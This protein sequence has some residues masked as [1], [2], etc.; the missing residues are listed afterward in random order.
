MPTKITRREFV[1][2]TVA[3]A[4]IAAG[5]K[6]SGVQTRRPNILFIL[7]DDLGYGDLSCYGRPDYQTSNLDRLA[8]EGVRF[9]NAY[10]AAPVCTPTRCAFITGRYPAR[11]RVGLEE[12]LQEKSI[13]GDAVETLGLPPE[14]P[15]VASLLK[16]NGYETALI[17]KWHLGYPPNFGPVQSGFEEFFGIMSGAV[18]FFTH[19]DMVGEGDLYEGKIPVERI[20]YLT[21]M[22]TTRAVEYISRR[23]ERGIRGRP[24]YLSLHY[25]AP[26]WPWEGPTDV[27]VSRALGRG[28]DG[29]TAGGSL[30]TYAEM[31][32]SL[33]E[34]IGEVLR[35]LTK[36]NLDRSTLVIFTSDNGGERFSY[37]WPFRGQ[38]FSLFEGGIRVPAIVRW[39]GRVLAGRVS[40]QTSITMDWT[41][42]ILAAGQTKSD[43]SFP[44]DG[45]DLL[46]VMTGGRESR[47]TY[48]RTFFWRNSNQDAVRRGHWK[49]L[50][51]GTREY[52]FD[53]AIDQREQADF[54]EQNPA[55]FDQ[56]RNEFQTWQS[57][58][59]PRP[60]ARPPRVL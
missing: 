5:S 4:A 14:Y 41:A 42:T 38:K 23:G 31:M 57:Q 9:V 53:L 24:F 20:G 11:T 16:A 1:S 29:F 44:L 46:P 37:N 56:L 34:G 60:P 47:A 55:M 12:P 2:A 10:S 45:D 33:D 6:L 39:P 40:E 30:K 54:R 52:L 58:V 19:K 13:L 17:G 59:L 22:L 28:Y 50:N 18:D 49:Y 35:A 48:D 26:H 43:P 25:T 3:G 7:A 36:A 15:T 21:N 51:D 8:S 32:K 27:A